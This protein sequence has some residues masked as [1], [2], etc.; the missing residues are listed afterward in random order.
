MCSHCGGAFKNKNDLHIHMQLHSPAGEEILPIF[1]VTEINRNSE[2]RNV[3]VNIGK[4]SAD[5][6]IDIMAIE[7]MTLLKNSVEDVK[8]FDS[9]FSPSSLFSAKDIVSEKKS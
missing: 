9:F 1:N 4:Y 8:F 2:T 7:E 6:Q 5:L 3:H